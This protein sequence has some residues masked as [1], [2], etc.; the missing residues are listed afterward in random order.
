MKTIQC[1]VLVIGGGATGA[2]VLRD[3]VMRGFKALLLEKMTYLL[4]RK[5][6]RYR[7]P[8]SSFLFFEINYSCCASRF[9]HTSYLP[10]HW[11]SIVEIVECVYGQQQVYAFVLERNL[12]FF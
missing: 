8:K 11:S 3:L 9:E 6:N 12:I 5:P 10:D 2:G 7:W 4:F 1:E